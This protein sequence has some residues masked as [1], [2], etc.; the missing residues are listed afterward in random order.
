MAREG[1][2]RGSLIEVKS[3][4]IDIPSTASPLEFQMRTGKRNLTYLYSSAAWPGRWFTGNY[5]R[6]CALTA[7]FSTSIATLSLHIVKS[8]E[9]N[10]LTSEKFVEAFV[11]SN[12]LRMDFN[13]RDISPT[14][15]LSSSECKLLNQL[16][17]YWLAG[18]QVRC[19]YWARCFICDMQMEDA[20]Q[21]IM[22]WADWYL[23]A[24][25]A[26]AIKILWR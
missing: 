26:K 14:R 19:N 16:K 10:A 1:V 4:L 17:I 9:I 15:L 2:S 20:Q 21:M 6:R 3:A 23:Q 18:L 13:Y 22:W 11:S 5:L 25:G 8:I 24:S 7:F 12:S